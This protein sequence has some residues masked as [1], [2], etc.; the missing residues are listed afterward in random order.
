[1]SICAY[2]RDGDR[3]QPRKCVGSIAHEFFRHEIRYTQLWN[4]MIQ[5]R[6][7]TT[8]IH[9]PRATATVLRRLVLSNGHLDLVRLEKAGESI[10]PTMEDCDIQEQFPTAT[11]Q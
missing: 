3:A 7:K 5:K 4:I 6:P 8:T 1:M 2:H 10:Q 11:A 9:N